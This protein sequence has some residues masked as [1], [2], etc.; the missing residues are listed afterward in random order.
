[1]DSLKSAQIFGFQKMSKYEILM[2][3]LD[4]AIITSNCLVVTYNILTGFG[5]KEQ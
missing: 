5:R 2:R 4:T 1:M 3:G